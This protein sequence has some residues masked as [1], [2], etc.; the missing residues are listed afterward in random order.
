MPETS[1]KQTSF[2]FDFS[3]KEALAEKPQNQKLKL[4]ARPKSIKKKTTPEKPLQVSEFLDRLNDNLK[5]QEFRIQGEVGRVSARANYHFFDLKDAQDESLL[6]CF[7]WANVFQICGF[8]PKEGLEVIV[9]GYPEIYKKRGSFNFQVKSIELKGEGVLKKAFDDLKKKLELEG[10]FSPEAKRPL[11]RFPKNIAIITSRHGEAI[12]DFLTNIGQFGFKLHLKDSRVEG[13]RAVFDLI[14]AVKMFNQKPERYDVLALVRGGGSWESLQAFNN[15]ELART[16]R[17]SKIPVLTGV[18]HEGDVT[19]AD[20]VADVRASTP[21]AAAKK[22]SENWIQARERVFNWENLI[23]MN[24]ARIL[25]EKKQEITDYTAGLKQGAAGISSYFQRLENEFKSGVVKLAG[26]FRHNREIIERN[27][28]VILAKFQD[29]LESLKQLI[30]VKADKIAANNPE[31]QLK[32]GYSL[33]FK[34][35]KLIRSV[36]EVNSG[37]ELDVQVADGKIKTQVK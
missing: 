18:G 15:E 25:T 19:I 30:Q 23:L 5:T 14:N 2:G 9:T 7:G 13:Q 20:L 11:P 36:K 35:G 16:L 4:K 10:L 17:A 26:I 29:D 8:Y 22:V 37:D 33:A 31:R 32:L 24:F 34:E 12:N 6:S 3:S 28:E 27:Q 1:L 21:T